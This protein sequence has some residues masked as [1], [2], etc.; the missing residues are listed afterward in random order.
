MPWCSLFVPP[1][2]CMDIAFI[3]SW[4][5]I[6]SQKKMEAVCMRGFGGADGEYYGIFESGQYR[7]EL[8]S[9]FR[10]VFL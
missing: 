6:K 4:D 5:H 2:F 1:E 8:H 3:F 10:I 9:D 7:Y